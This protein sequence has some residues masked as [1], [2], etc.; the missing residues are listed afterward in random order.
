MFKC[1]SGECISAEKVCDHQKDCTDFSDEP[2][3][4]GKL[5]L[6]FHQ[7]LLS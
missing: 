5:G 2:E 6:Y 4:C 3:Q 1:L 7:L